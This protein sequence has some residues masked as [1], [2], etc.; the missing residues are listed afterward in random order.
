[1]GAHVVIAARNPTKAEAAVGDIRKR[2]PAA[3]IE[4]L[5]LDLAS[6]ASVRAFA[7]TFTARFDHLDVLV[8]NAG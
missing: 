3:T 4:H 8:N 2:A 1:M 5:P 7:D 6:F